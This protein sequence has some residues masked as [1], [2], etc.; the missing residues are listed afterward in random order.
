[1]QV[2]F[3]KIIKKVNIM[4]SKVESHIIIGIS[5]ASGAV[6]GVKLLQLLQPIADIK[7]HLILSKPAEMTIKA[8]MNMSVD[9]II[10]LS[11]VYHNNKNIGACVASGSFNVKAMFIAPCS[12]KTMSEIASGVT[13]TLIS[14]SA[15]VCLKERKPLILGVREMP[16]HSGHLRNM[17]HLSDLGAYIAPP[18]PAFYTNPQTIDDIVTQICC[19]WLS[20]ASIE[21]PQKIT[22]TGL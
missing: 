17:A 13:T 9:D 10:A 19:R 5:G 16:F 21:L 1:M 20:F 4:Q 14:R 8:E 18:V 6:F 2:F 12:I 22:W 3:T 15:D 7:T 11:D